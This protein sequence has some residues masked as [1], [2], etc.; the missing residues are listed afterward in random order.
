MQREE[1]LLAI[2]NFSVR[3]RVLNKSS[4]FA[5]PAKIKS[6]K[7]NLNEC[8]GLIFEEGLILKILPLIEKSS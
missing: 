7:I 6:N 1:T 4:P 5:G 2:C 3:D 8:I